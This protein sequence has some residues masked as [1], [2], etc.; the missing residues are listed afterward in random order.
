MNSVEYYLNHF[1]KD[2]QKLMNSHEFA[3]ERISI[4]SLF[5][6]VETPDDHYLIVKNEFNNIKEKPLFIM[7][8]FFIVL[9][10]QATYSSAKSIY[11][12]FRSI[13]MYPKLSGI[14]SSYTSNLHPAMLLM[15]SIKITNN[16]KSILSDFDEL[17]KHFLNEY[18]LLFYEKLPEYINDL[19][20]KDTRKE[21]FLK[22]MDE[23][24]SAMKW[25]SVPKSIWNNYLNSEENKLFKSLIEIFTI[26]LEKFIAYLLN[27]N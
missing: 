1:S 17:T 26:R 11:S 8:F 19:N 4:V 13:T 16:Y 20:H 21:Y 23:I 27:K 14:L 5:D 18:K 15:I 22:I 6:F 3:K 2:L 10:D 12:K 9:I 7:N 24:N 25:D